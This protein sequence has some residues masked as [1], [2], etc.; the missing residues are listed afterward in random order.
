MQ[1]NE[2]AA[3]LQRHRSA[4]ARDLAELQK[5]QPRYAKWQPVYPDICEFTVASIGN[6]QA[7]LSSL[8]EVAKKSGWPRTQERLCDALRATYE[9][10]DEA[11]IVI[12]DYA[13][14]SDVTTEDALRKLKRARQQLA[15][16][17][18][19]V[20]GVLGKLTALSPSHGGV[21]VV[22][23]ELLQLGS[24]RRGV[25]GIMTGCFFLDEEWPIELHLANGTLSDRGRAYSVVSIQVSC[26]AFR[27]GFAKETAAEICKTLGVQYHDAVFFISGVTE[28][29]LQISILRLMNAMLLFYGIMVGAC[30]M[31]GELLPEPGPHKE[32]I[33][34]WPAGKELRPYRTIDEG[35]EA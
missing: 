26:C 27:R 22:E 34:R 13:P 33:P 30:R 7:R 4:I 23:A 6:V 2:F 32:H 12:L 31:I 10:G 14:M 24:P 9:Q 17:I 20:Q 16:F 28:E 35:D 8:L 19:E 1:P 5:W 25:G 11:A 15:A 21:M 29:N 3:L 18:E